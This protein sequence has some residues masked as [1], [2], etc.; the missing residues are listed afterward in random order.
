MLVLCLLMLAIPFAVAQDQLQ[1][2]GPSADTPKPDD[3]PPISIT[4]PDIG[5]TYVYGILKHRSL[6]WNQRDQM[7]LARLTFT[8]D[9][10]DVNSPQDDTIDFRLPGITFDEAKGVFSAKTAKGAVIPV[11]HVT[12]QLF[13]KTIAVLP[14]ARV[15]VIRD[16]G[17]VTVILE[18]V[19]SDDPSLKTP[20]GPP[21]A[22]PPAKEKDYFN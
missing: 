8:E 10:L 21:P 14:N 1:P 4:S 19:S 20:P 7:L 16:H 6:V 11:A 5:S 18:A 12:R 17:R 13:F 3:G 2:D 22:A 15:R 9:S